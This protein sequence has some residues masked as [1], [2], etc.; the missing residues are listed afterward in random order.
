MSGNLAEVSEDGS[1]LLHTISLRSP[2]RD[3]VPR[4]KQ[5][6]VHVGSWKEGGGGVVRV[7][8]GVPVVHVGSWKEGG[9]G[10][11]R[12]GGVEGGGY[13]LPTRDTVQLC[14]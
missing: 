14:A 12:V 13:L 9:G 1:D 11:V 4:G 8:E 2:F 6:V 5:P 3:A 10:L 7:L